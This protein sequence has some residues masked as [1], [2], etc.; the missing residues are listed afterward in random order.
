MGMMLI[1]QNRD[2]AAQWF[3]GA[4]EVGDEEVLSALGTFYGWGNG[5]VLDESEKLSEVRRYAQRDESEAQQMM[6]FLYGEGWGAKRD[7]VKAE[8]WFDKAAASGDVASV[9]CRLAVVCRNG[10]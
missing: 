2:A 10:A 5:P 8:Y 7:P 6:G 3:Y 4:A 9:D 1:H